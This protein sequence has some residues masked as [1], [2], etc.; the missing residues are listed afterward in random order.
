[1]KSLYSLFN[2]KYN[3]LMLIKRSD[4]QAGFATGYLVSIILLTIVVIVM[5]GLTIWFYIQY[6]DQ[7]NNVDSK[8][9]QAVAI[10]VKEQADEDE[11]KFAEREKE[12]NREFVG[13]DDYGRVT[14]SY[15][16]TWS[17]YV[18]KDQNSKGD[19]EAYLHPQVVPS[20][21][22]KES[23]FALRVLIE[24]EDSSEVIS[25]YDSK[26]EDGE[27]KSSAINANGV[28]GTRL[29][30]AFDKNVRGAVVIFKVRDKTVSIFTDADTFKP[31]FE[32][33][34]KTIKF[35]Q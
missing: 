15:P 14:F 2:H 10:A 21:D 34:I 26:V 13:P 17:A 9:N 33:I 28:S 8:V 20:V 4:R 35:N 5:V 30:G 24:T 3:D 22:N 27:L 1:M 31:D 12:P 6:S 16:K 7:K 23:R 18:D 29:D 32:N 19:Y 25:Q 11:K